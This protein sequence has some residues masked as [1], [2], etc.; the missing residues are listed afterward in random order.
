MSD[1][2]EA[3]QRLI[4]AA[5]PFLSGDVVDETTGTIPL[6]Q[7]LQDAITAAEKELE[8]WHHQN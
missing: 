2:S 3:L 7:A 5:K 6:M 4:A 8:Q 1:V